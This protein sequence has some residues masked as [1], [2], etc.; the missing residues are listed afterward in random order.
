M[1]RGD[2]RRGAVS[3]AAPL[4]L[5][6]AARA[7]G[8]QTQRPAAAPPRPDAAVPQI[9]TVRPREPLRFDAQLLVP[10]YY[11]RNFWH[12][13]RAGVELVVPAPAA[14]RAD[15]ATGRAATAPAAAAAPAPRARRAPGRATSRAPR[16][17]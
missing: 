9:V 14:A 3:F 7:A 10:A 13:I 16:P 2:T 1:R 5:L 12:S 4:L 6:L 11:E 8:A 15:A 17:R